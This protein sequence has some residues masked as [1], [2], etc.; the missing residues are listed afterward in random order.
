MNHSVNNELNTYKT[1]RTMLTIRSLSLILVLMFSGTLIIAQEKEDE[2][3][4]R[5]EM[6]KQMR[7]RKE[8]LE[9][10]HQQMKELQKQRE[11]EMKIIIGE[12]GREREAFLSTGSGFDFHFLNGFD[13]GTH[14]QLT[15]RKNFNGTT[16]TSKGKFDVEP[17]I[18]HFRCMIKGSVKSGEISILVEYPDGKVFKE[19]TINSSADI[20]YNQSVSI[21]EG[22]ESKYEGSWNYVIKAEQAEGSYM[23]QISTN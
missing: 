7:I 4:R 8:M 1:M 9:E 20:S 22:E 12:P 18:R 19:L 11:E 16:D 21:K 17:D 6:E 23:L 10:Q 15:L 13:Q 5:A 14:S 2:E 3:E